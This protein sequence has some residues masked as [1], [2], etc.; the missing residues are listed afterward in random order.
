MVPE[1][2]MVVRHLLPVALD[3]AG[4]REQASE[5]RATAPVSSAQEVAEAAG[6]VHAMAD[7]IGPW[8]S[9]VS[10]LLFWAEAA[11]W[12]AFR[13]DIESMVH[14]MDR[15]HDLTSNSDQTMH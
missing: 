6:L 2:D 3:A 13:G 1:A 14:H 9:T 7:Q 12:A 5:L 8:D 11:V 4:A 10:E 15:I